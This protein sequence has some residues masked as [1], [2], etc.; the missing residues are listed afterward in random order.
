MTATLFGGTTL[1][2]LHPDHGA[3]DAYVGLQRGSRAAKAIGDGLVDSFEA[4]RAERFRYL[5]RPTVLAVIF[6]AIARLGEGWLTLP[7]GIF[8]A[9]VAVMLVQD[10]RLAVSVADRV[11]IGGDQITYESL[12]A[13]VLPPWARFVRCRR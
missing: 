10:F 1:K 13:R 7:A 9:I 4:P 2:V 8:F 5:A 12:S 11:A 6:I 3:A